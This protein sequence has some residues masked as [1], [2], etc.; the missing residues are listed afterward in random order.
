MLDDSGARRGERSSAPRERRADI[1]LW[2]LATLV[3][4]GFAV[5]SLTAVASW[6]QWGHNGYNGAAFWQAARNSLRF[7]VVGQA[8]YHMEHTAPPASVV[9]THHPLL[10]HAHL[11]L[12]QW[13]FGPVEW[14]GRLVPAIYSLLTPP[15]LFFVVARLWDRPTALA[16]AF[17][18]AVTPLNLIF[19]NMIDHEQ[20]AIVFLLLMLYAY[21]RWH[22]QGGWRWLAMMGAAFSLAAQF[23]WPAYYMAAF[24]A[25]D[26]TVV[27]LFGRGRRE[28]RRRYVAFVL[29]FSA[30]VLANFLGFFGWIALM[31]GDLANMAA[32][33]GHRTSEVVGYWSGV[34]NRSLDLQGPLLLVLFGAWLSSWTRRG[35][36]RRRDVLP[37]FFFAAQLLHSTVFKQAGHLHSYWTWYANPALA[38]GGAEVLV[39]GVRWLHARIAATARAR[40]LRGALVAGLALAAGLQVGLAAR[41]W[42]WGFDTGSASYVFGP[43]DD[44]YFHEIQWARALGATF[45]REQTRY[46]IHSSVQR[47]RIE[48]MIYL[49]APSM[50]TSRIP[51]PGAPRSG[52]RGHHVFILD[53][54]HVQLDAAARR[55]LA[56]L[57][58]AHPMRVWNRRFVAFD[59]AESGAE[60]VGHVAVSAP[61]S[62]LWRWL[63]HPSRPP[64]RWDADPDREV[65]AG[66]FAARSEVVATPTVGGE[67]GRPFEWLCPRGQRLVALEGRLARR[68]VVVAALRPRCAGEASMSETAGPWLG[69]MP[70]EPELELRCAAGRAMTGLSGRAGAL[71]DRVEARCG[72]TSER[73]GGDGGAEFALTCP[74]GNVVMGLAGRYGARI[75]ALSLRCAPEVSPGSPVSS[76]VEQP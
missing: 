7:G 20:G 22:E 72:G 51:A 61:A 45:P 54:H 36:P 10:L 48:F 18:Y 42:R 40:L 30:L 2:T 71:V 55:Q 66:L 27:G 64:I 39:I 28:G 52:G 29:G 23:D 16:A 75:D 69:E 56:A 65:L 47:R 4:V 3:F 35:L 49:D 12:T 67:G 59:L 14:A 32:A 50:E 58:A 37:W 19:A 11:V 21:V 43:T 13:L 70:E 76:T 31:R 57:A 8:L 68:P 17:L 38:I 46:L 44:D 9:Y 15:L 73:M 60:L 25:A 41:Q 62:W 74:E 6:W 24:M 34:W 63:V 33:F 1:W 26:T 53:L 5:V